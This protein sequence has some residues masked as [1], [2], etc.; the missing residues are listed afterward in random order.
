MVKSE[1]CLQLQ[2]DSQTPVTDLRTQVPLPFK[3]K[4]CSK[5]PRLFCPDLQSHS[6]QAQKNDEKHK[7]PAPNKTARLTETTWILPSRLLFSYRISF[8]LANT[9]SEWTEHCWAFLASTR[10][11][12]WETIGFQIS[13]SPKTPSSTSW[14]GGE[15]GPCAKS[16]A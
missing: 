6:D 16:Y 8:P 3:C 15:K 11:S 14:M 12:S 13:S 4:P 9:T 7:K 5:S 10:A 1:G 2:W